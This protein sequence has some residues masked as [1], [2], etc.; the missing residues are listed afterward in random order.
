MSLKISICDILF[1]KPSEKRRILS[2]MDAGRKI[3]IIGRYSPASPGIT[4][5]KARRRSQTREF[6]FFQLRPYLH[7]QGRFGNMY[8][9]RAQA[10]VPQHV[11]RHVATNIGG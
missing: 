6:P 2:L 8:M 3:T 10:M 5:P 11:A 9:N 7:D 4:W 1:T